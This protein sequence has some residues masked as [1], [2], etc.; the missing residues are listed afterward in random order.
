MI[1]IGLLADNIL[2]EFRLNTLK[3]ILE[4]SN[5]SIKVAIIDNRPKKSLMKNL[6]KI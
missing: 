2:S 3:P 1:K 5:Y 6:K 4:D